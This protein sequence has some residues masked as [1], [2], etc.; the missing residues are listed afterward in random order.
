MSTLRHSR[1]HHRLTHRRWARHRQILLELLYPY[2]EA[3]PAD[4][5]THFPSHRYGHKAKF[6]CH[7]EEK[8][9]RQRVRKALWYDE[10]MPR[11]RHEYAD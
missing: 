8:R 2:W 1:R 6:A 7:A 10:P 3:T 11:Y 5:D 4:Y 9:L